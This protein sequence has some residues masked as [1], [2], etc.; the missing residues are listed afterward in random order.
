[1]NEPAVKA[2][3]NALACGRDLV[4]QTSQV[5]RITGLLNWHVH[6]TLYGA[7]VERRGQ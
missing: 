2:L 1:M 7:S 5:G 4:I 6:A 3:G